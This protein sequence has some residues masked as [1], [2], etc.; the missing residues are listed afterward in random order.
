MVC[1]ERTATA[2]PC[3]GSS[4]LFSAAVYVF[5]SV[6][7]HLPTLLCTT[8]MLQAYRELVRCRRNKAARRYT[9]FGS[10]KSATRKPSSINIAS[11]RPIDLTVG[12]SAPETHDVPKLE[13]RTFYEG[14]PAG[15]W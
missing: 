14:H 1:S 3:P 8:G 7:V 5:C 4:F 11:V 6:L 15:G 10:A 12:G 13:L 2:D 9:H